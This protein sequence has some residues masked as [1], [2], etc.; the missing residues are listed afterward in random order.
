MSSSIKAALTANG[1]IALAKTAGAVFTG[2]ASMAA[3][4]VHSF[5]DCGNQ[6]LLLWGMHTSKKDADTEHP[7]GYGMNVYFWSFVVALILFSL[8]GVYS[9]YEGFHKLGNPEPLKHVGWAVAILAFGFFMELRSFRVCIAEIRAK[10]PGKSMFWFFKETRSP[11]LLVIFGEDF[12]ALIG[13]GVAASFL[14]IAWVTGNPMWDAIGSIC[15]GVL[16]ITVACFL[17]W[18][19]KA[20]LIGQSAGPSTRKALRQR[21][22]DREEIEHV[23]ECITLQMG[24]EV[25][26]MLRVRMTEKEDAQKLLNDIN[27]IEK[28]IFAEFP[29]FTT[30]FVE[31]DN[32]FEDF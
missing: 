26:L 29:Q 6:L 13:L 25:V 8:G 12:A 23:Y 32:K 14:G 31:P 7:L 21:L 27:E 10:Y 19:T 17:F 3:E 20:L 5:A 28:A 18:E 9:F 30:I 4:A 11:D 15:V 1:S 2:S 16:L 24:T 22:F